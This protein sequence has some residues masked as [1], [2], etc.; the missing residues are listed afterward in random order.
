MTRLANLQAN[1]LIDLDICRLV[2]SAESCAAEFDL[3]QGSGPVRDHNFIIGRLLEHGKTFLELLDCFE[4]AVSRDLIRDGTHFANFATNTTRRSLDVPTMFS[5]FTCYVSLVRM[6]RV[7]LSAMLDSIPFFRTMPEPPRLFPGWSL[8]GYS[9][10][11]RVDLQIRIL[12][13]ITEELLR[14]GEAKLGLSEDNTL[15]SPVKFEWEGSIDLLR[16]MLEQEAREQPPVEIP[17]G[18]CESLPQIIARLKVI[19]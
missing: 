3:N 1:I 7:M 11:D 6:N 13:Q 4:A 10:E 14:K 12:V 17:R 15:G 9:I 16:T 19:L 2:R 5:I 8:G 18:H